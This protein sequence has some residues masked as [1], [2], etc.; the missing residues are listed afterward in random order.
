MNQIQ[1]TKKCLKQKIGK[2]QNTTNVDYDYDRH[3]IK[4]NN[5]DFKCTTSNRTNKKTAN[6]LEDTLF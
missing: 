4:V 2:I 3:L 5:F 1:F 6:I